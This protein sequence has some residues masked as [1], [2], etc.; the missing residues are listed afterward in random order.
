ML[1]LD[2]KRTA[3]ILIDVQKGTLGFNIGY[4][5]AHHMKPA[6]HWSQ[7]AAFHWAEVAPHVPDELYRPVSLARW[8]QRRR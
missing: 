4:H 6:L 7:L 3:L 2:A 1:T 8:R 5:S